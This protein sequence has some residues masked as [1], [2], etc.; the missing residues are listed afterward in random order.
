MIF[1]EHEPAAAA[2]IEVRAFAR[3]CGVNEDPVCGNGNGCVAAFIAI[4]SERIR[5]GGMAV[6]CIDG[7]LLR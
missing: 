3:A 7:Q 1:G 2:R 4:G 5:V 6:T